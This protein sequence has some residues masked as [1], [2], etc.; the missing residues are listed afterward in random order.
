MLDLREYLG[1]ITAY[2]SGK[3]AASMLLDGA[4]RCGDRIVVVDECGVQ[5]ELEVQWMQWG[6][7]WVHLAL[8]G[9][10]VTFPSSEKLPAGAKVYRAA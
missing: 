4:L 2:N 5:L 7:A 9:W 6:N 10:M 8:R 3:G 1:E